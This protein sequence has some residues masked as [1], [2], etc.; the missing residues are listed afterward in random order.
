MGINTKLY[1]VKKVMFVYNFHS[2]VN[3]RENR[4]N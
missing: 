3:F 1:C 4:K 2:G